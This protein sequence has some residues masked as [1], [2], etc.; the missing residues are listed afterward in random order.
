MSD[1]PKFYITTPIYYPSG[2]WH[3]GTCYTTVVCDAIAR[4]KRMQGYDVM[5]LTGTDEHGQ[6]VARLA[7]A[8][9]KTPK[10]YVD[11]PV[12]ELKE[13]WKLIGIS[14]DKFIRTTDEEHVACV[15]KIFKKL[16]ENGDIYKKDYEGWYCTPCETFWTETQLKDGKCPDCGRPVEKTKES[17]YFFR[18]SK[19][20]DKLIELLED[21][22]NGFLEPSSRRHEMLNN[23]LKAGLQDLCVT[24]TSFKWGV[25]VPFDEGHVAYVW[26]DALSN[27][28]TALGYLSD[29]PSLFEKF[30]P[31]DVHMMA[32]EIVRFHSVIWPA[33]LMSL[34]LPLPKK[35]Y[36]HGWLMYGGGKISK[37]KASGTLP[38]PVDL[39]EHYGVD[40]LRYYL[41]REVPFGQDGN[42]TNEA[43]LNRINSDLVNDLGNLLSRTTA[44]IT[45]YFGGV[46]PAPEEF[47]E[48]DRE[49]VDAAN[50]AF[51]EVSAFVDALQI[52][53]ALQ[54]VFALVARA[55]KYIDETTP[56]TL[57]K[58]PEER[59]RLGTVL[60]VLAE[61]LRISA[62]LLLPFIQNAPQK[63]F[64][65]LSCETP[66]LFNDNVKFGFLKAGTKITKAGILYPRIDI[67]KELSAMDERAEK[68]AHTETPAKQ[69]EKK[70]E[71]KKEERKMIGIEDFMNVD[72]RVGKVLECK[73]LEKS[74]KLLVSKIEVGDEVRTIVSGIAQ[75]YTPEEMV[76][77][78][79]VVV[80]NLA[81]A[82][83]CGVTSEGMIL[84][85]DGADGNVV[86]V[87]PETLVKSGSR[88]R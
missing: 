28:I 59:G 35:V 6:K 20:Q 39:V 42:Y 69:P 52:P 16:Y 56:W 60:Y 88:V 43:F 13:I 76:G 57:A 30:W 71:E 38:S 22:K 64:A 2:K 53:S 73:K 70:C 83:L 37:S 80:A 3:I 67:K 81:P 47:N 46:L 58:N 62:V 85:A 75:Y 63:I 23:F 48:L 19:Y 8:A 44:M 1:K 11:G 49:L 21:E 79:V 61:I 45:Q 14:Y 68:A 36:G 87:S 17:S 78:S 82:T 54:T 5:F 84:C 15:Q 25:P 77:K 33:L 4:F 7:E 12:A 18:L 51:S 50:S 34:G 86:I 31:A 26:V 40:A 55:N 66:A 10:E 65:D 32:K 24:R 9:G 27:Y 41:L 29:D 74:K 72:L